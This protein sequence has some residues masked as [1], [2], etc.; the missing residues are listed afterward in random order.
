MVLDALDTGFIEGAGP[1]YPQ[2]KTAIRPRPKRGFRDRLY[3]VG[4]SPES[5]LQAAE[6]GARL[7]VFSQMPWEMFAE[8]TLPVYR[9]HYRKVHGREAPPVLTV[10]LLACHAD[11][12]RAEA[13]ARRHMAAYYVEVM[14]HY[15]IMSEHFKQLRGYDHYAGAADVLKLMKLEDVAAAYTDVQTWGTSAA[16]VEKLRRRRSLL[17]DFELSVIVG[18]GGMPFDEAERSLRLFA[19]DVIPTLRGW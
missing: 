9:G 15:E 19:S 5:V 11:A 6:L 3:A 18:Y 12:E 14:R 16:I 2:A 17:G 10:D 7:M 1:F 4:M 13:L 8:Q